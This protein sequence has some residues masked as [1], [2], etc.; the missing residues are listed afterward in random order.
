MFIILQPT[1]LP[2]IGV[3]IM[4]SITSSSSC[5]PSTTVVPVTKPSSNLRE[6]YKIIASQ[7]PNKAYLLRCLAVYKVAHENMEEAI[8]IAESSLKRDVFQG[9]TALAELAFHLTC[10]RENLTA[11]NLKLAKQLSTKAYE[12]CKE[13]EMV[14]TTLEKIKEINL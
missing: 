14:R 12:Y 2:K 10:D 13:S 11:D 3:L 7:E 6:V 8:A 1:L 5:F 9:A 4:S